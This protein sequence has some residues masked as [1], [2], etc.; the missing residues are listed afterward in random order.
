MNQATITIPN[1][2]CGVQG[3]LVII[4]LNGEINHVWCSACGRRLAS[5]LEVVEE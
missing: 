2:E 3:D 5:K 1:C 4:M